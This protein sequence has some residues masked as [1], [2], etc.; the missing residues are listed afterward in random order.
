M[1]IEIKLVV[2]TGERQVGRGNTGGGDKNIFFSQCTRKHD[3]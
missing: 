1:D 3:P 2:T